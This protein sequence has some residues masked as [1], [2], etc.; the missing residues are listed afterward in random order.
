MGERINKTES[1]SGSFRMLPFQNYIFYPANFWPHKNHEA[2][3]VAFAMASRRG[4]PESVHL[5]LTGE[6]SARMYELRKATETMGIQHRVHFLGYISNE[7]IVEVL[8]NSL[9]LLFP[10]LYEGFGI[11]VVEAQTAGV[12][13]ACSS[14]TSLPEVAGNG[15]LFLD[16][17]KPMA[18]AEAIIQITQNKKLRQD[19]IQKGFIN[20][21]RFSNAKSMAKDYLKFF[22]DTYDRTAVSIN[23]VARDGWVR[24]KVE[25][26]NH[27][28]RTVK[29][30]INF[31]RPKELSNE[32]LWYG[33]K[34][35]SWLPR[36]W[37]KA[38]AGQKV[39]IELAL[40]PKR[41]IS[42]KFSPCNLS[43][44]KNGNNDGESSGF[45]CKIQECT[46][47]IEKSSLEIAMLRYP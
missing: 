10:S 2:L 7:E 43:V 40:S 3:L 35:K 11:P 13:V 34:S 17:R 18:M 39:K 27:L 23:G 25:I 14:V 15:A 12:P 32:K 29:I 20:A 44:A 41:I 31:I 1:L 47:A 4:L 24:R 38:T 21:K 8:K 28:S 5:V 33:I 42:I 30:K 6:E 26:Q 46:Y 45:A 36:L 22:S 9:A 37:K 19:L 16:P